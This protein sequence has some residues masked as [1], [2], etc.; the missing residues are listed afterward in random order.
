MESQSQLETLNSGLAKLRDELTRLSLML[1][2]FKANLD[3]QEDGATVK[4]T[5]EVLASAKQGIKDKPIQ[6]N[7]RDDSC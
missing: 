1:K 4:Y 2:D 6:K 3:I 7:S 5:I